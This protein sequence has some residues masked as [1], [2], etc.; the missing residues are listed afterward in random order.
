MWAITK[1]LL[2]INKC[3]IEKIRKELACKECEYLENAGEQRQSKLF[4]WR[5][6]GRWPRIEEKRRN[7]PSRW[8]QGSNSIRAV[9]FLVPAQGK[10]MEGVLRLTPPSLTP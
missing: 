7:K 3:R 8:G 6:G 1:D 4:C 10:G 2:R 9:C 5:S